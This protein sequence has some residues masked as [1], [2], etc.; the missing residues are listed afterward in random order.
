M[1]LSLRQRRR[2]ETAR[3]IQNATL[4]LALLRGLDTITTEE[5]AVAAGVSTRTF[6]NYFTNKESATIG[7]PPGYREDDLTALRTGTASLGID[8]K[9]FLDRHMEALAS[10]EALLRK[11]RKIA[12]TSAKAR[13]IL[14]GYLKAECDDL[15]D[16]L[17]G[18][19]KNRQIAE[20]L[21]NNAVNTTARAI[22][23]WEHDQGIELA[24]ALDIVWEGQIA[25]SRLLAS[26]H[27]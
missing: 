17:C 4:S 2:S 8:L 21:A 18:R 19:V 11:V 22:F 5:I 10:D 20:A 14:D 23:L 13:S 7:S 6:F 27:E 3:E 9:Q 1:T 12:Q 24:K 26:S 16:C 25:A 15:A